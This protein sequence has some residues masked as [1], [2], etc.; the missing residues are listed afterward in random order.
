MIKVEKLSPRVRVSECNDTITQ[1]ITA[2]KSSALTTETYLSNTFGVLETENNALSLA[3]NRATEESELDA[4][5]VKRDECMRALYYYVQGQSYNPDAATKAAA[6]T[7]LTILDQY[8]LDVLRQTYSAES[9]LI[10]SMLTDLADETV[11]LSVSV[12]PAC[13]SLIAALQEAQQNFSSQRAAY[14]ANKASL[15]TEKSAYELKKAIVPMLNKSVVGYLNAMMGMSLHDYNTF[16]AQVAEII[17]LANGVIKRR[18]TES[19][20]EVE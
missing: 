13:A 17:Q 9:A 19:A 15:Q 12:L 20:I 14:E 11:Q 10:H 8:G 6:N 7:V 18:I 4:Y 5:D 3:L 1:I 16:S 2:F